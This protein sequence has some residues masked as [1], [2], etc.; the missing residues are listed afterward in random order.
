M[1][2]FG[3]YSSS[4]LIGFGG[5]TTGREADHSP[6]SSA[7]AKNVWSYTST[8]QYVLMACCLSSGYGFMASCSVKHRDMFTFTNLFSTFYPSLDVVIPCFR[9]V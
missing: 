3:S 4:Y 1:I 5:K 9:A 6:S 2:G 7:E 8:S